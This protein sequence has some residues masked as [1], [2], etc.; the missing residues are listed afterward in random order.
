MLSPSHSPSTTLFS[1][2]V[3]KIAR[4]LDMTP[5]QVLLSWHVQRGVGPSYIVL[6]ASTQTSVQTVVLPKSVHTSRVQEN[7]HVG[8]L[9]DADFRVLEDAA[10]AHPPKR[11]ANP[12]KSWGLDFDIFD[13]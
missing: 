4:E 13:D 9:P 2:Q 3:K 11:V 7:C 1:I 12:S 6:D 8:K 5:A 10:C